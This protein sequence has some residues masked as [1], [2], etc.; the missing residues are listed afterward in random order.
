MTEEGQ[1]PNR[2]TRVKSFGGMELEDPMSNKSWVINAQRLKPY[3]CGEIERIITMI[4]LK[5]LQRNMR[6][7]I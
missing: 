6:Q 3:L 1:P 2:R 7:V 4:L 5:E